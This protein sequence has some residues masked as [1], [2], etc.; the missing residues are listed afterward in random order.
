M[1][2]DSNDDNI[3][4]GRNHLMQSIFLFSFFKQKKMTSTFVNRL[5]FSVFLSQTEAFL[6]SNEHNNLKQF[7]TLF[8]FG[9]EIRDTA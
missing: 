4:K 8:F 2:V 6:F 9:L 1:A 7:L 5:K 3:E